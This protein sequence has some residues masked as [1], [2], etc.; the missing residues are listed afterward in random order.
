MRQILRARYRLPFSQQ[1]CIYSTYNFPQFLFWLFCFDQTIAELSTVLWWCFSLGTIFTSSQWIIIQ[2]TVHIKSQVRSEC[3]CLTRCACTFFPT[4]QQWTVDS[5]DKRLRLIWRFSFANPFFFSSSLIIYK[6][7]ALP[8]SLLQ[9]QIPSDTV[10][11]R[12]RL[13][14]NSIDSNILNGKFKRTFKKK[15]HFHLISI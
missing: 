6:V 5:Y 13:W 2:C 7:Q 8:R 4:L 15:L 1:T 9:K 11:C 10:H 14:Q 3:E 12:F